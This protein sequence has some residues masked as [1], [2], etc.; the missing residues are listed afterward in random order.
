MGLV[1]TTARTGLYSLVLVL[2]LYYLFNLRTLNWRSFFSILITP[3][4]FVR[5]FEIVLLKR[6]KQSLLSSSGRVQNYIDALQIFSSNPKN[7]LVGIGLG[8]EEIISRGLSF[9]P[10]NFIIQFLLQLG[11]L[12]LIFIF[13]VFLNYY[14]YDF[15]HS[16]IIKW[17]ILYIVISSM[18]VPDIFSSRFLSVVLVLATIEKCKGYNYE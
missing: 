3:V 5:I 4:L 8:K 11:I 17:I 1:T 2:I 18:F 6:G 7:I 10:H 14:Y 12:G 13:L 9:I 15:S 16:G